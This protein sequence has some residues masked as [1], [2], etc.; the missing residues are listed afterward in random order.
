MLDRQEVLDLLYAKYIAPTKDKEKLYIGVEIEMPLINLAKGPVD[1]GVIHNLTRRFKDEFGFNIAVIDDEKNASSLT[2]FLTDD[3]LSYDCS[4]NNLELSFGKEDTLAAISD[5]LGKYYKFIQSVLGESGYT[6]SGL[7]I[8]PYRDFNNNVPIPNGR[9][10]M[11]FHHLSSYDQYRT[12]MFFHPSPNYGMFSSASQ[13]QLDIRYDD[14][15]ETIQ[16]FSLLEPIKA[17]L[18]SN[19]VLTGDREEMLCCRDM[20]WEN[21]THG[22]NPHNVGMFKKIPDDVDELLEYIASQSIYCTIQDGKYINF[23]PINIVDY[24]ASKS[25]TGEYFAVGEYKTVEFSPRVSDLAYL[26]TFKFIDLTFR[27][28]IEFRSICCQPM[29]DSLTVAAFHLGLIRQPRALLDLLVADHAL[30]HRGFNAA[31]LRTLFNLRE[32]PSFAGKDEVKKLLVDVLD[33]AAS[34][35]KS[36]GLGEEAYLAPLYERAEILEN[37]AQEL[38]RRT[39]SGEDVAEVIKDYAKI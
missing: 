31:E 19:S 39:E 24:F 6:A 4:Y 22:I 15:I 10:R 16:A 26:R 36:R 27:G 1:F 17:I 35:L 11:L 30:Y 34:G 33:L 13:V 32:W 21:S 14:L 38:L 29:R 18:F 3:I 8:N 23:P 7:G 12:P 37:P 28:T 9:Y 5:R 20:L 2:H 25:L